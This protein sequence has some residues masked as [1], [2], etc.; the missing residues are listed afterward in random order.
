M[1]RPDPAPSRLRGME[2]ALCRHAAAAAGLL[3]LLHAPPSRALQVVEARDGVTVRAALSTREPTRIRIEGAP[4]VDV[5]G[6]VQA[7]ACGDVPGGAAAG[8]VPTARSTADL[9][10]ECDRDK[11]EIYVR[12]SARG[13]DG[14]RPVSLF[15]SSARATYTLLLQRADTPADTIVIRDR[16]GGRAGS[17]ANGTASAS[18]PAHHVRA[19]KAM[20]VAMASDRVPGDIRV[21]EVGQP[22]QLWAGSRF[23]LMRRYE[24]RGLWGEKYLLQNTGGAVM[25]LAEQEFDRPDSLTG[26]Q[27]L[28]VAVENHNLRPGDSTS[29]FVIRRGGER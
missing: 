29:V 4:I 14:G 20:L 6:N 28:G 18:P 19:M 5:F 2:V 12:P 26:G 9:V 16:S 17:A 13:R 21:E 15:V 24:G 3:A 8:A 23:S 10:V 27:V 1:R 22:V 25:V 7:G 11:G